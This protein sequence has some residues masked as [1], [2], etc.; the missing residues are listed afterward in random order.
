[1]NDSAI[2]QDRVDHPLPDFPK[3]P[4]PEHTPP[5]GMSIGRTSVLRK[6]TRAD[7][8]LEQLDHFRAREEF[9]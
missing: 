8:L 2:A 6:R 7:E 4:T 5:I 9:L 1:M 3:L